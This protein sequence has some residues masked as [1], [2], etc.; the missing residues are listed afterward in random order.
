MLGTPCPRGRAVKAAAVGSQGTQVPWGS[1]GCGAGRRICSPGHQAPLR[2]WCPRGSQ[3]SWWLLL[4]SG[5]SP[6]LAQG[7]GNRRRAGEPLQQ[8]S[9][10]PGSSFPPWHLIS[11]AVSVD[12]LSPCAALPPPCSSGFSFPSL[13]L[14]ALFFPSVVVCLSSPTS[15]AA[16]T[17]PRVISF[18]HPTPRLIYS[19][20]GSP[21]STG[22][23]GRA[24]SARSPPCSG[25]EPGSPGRD[26]CC[27]ACSRPSSEPSLAGRGGP[28]PCRASR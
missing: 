8:P 23:A 21:E 3:G 20:P 2:P 22:G 27:S 14:R 25:W 7:R 19:E 17:P 9:A 12:H 16:N 5:H 18:P 24:G 1:P 26:A 6:A 4:G 28:S 13:W 11:T 10:F 15:V